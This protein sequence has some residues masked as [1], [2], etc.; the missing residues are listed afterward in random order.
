MVCPDVDSVSSLTLPEHWARDFFMAALCL[1]LQLNAESLERLEPLSALF[2]HSESVLLLAATAQ[3]NLRN[4]AEAQGLF[5]ELSERD[6][7][8]IEG[9]SGRRLQAYASTEGCV[10]ALAMALSHGD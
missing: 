8:R 10:S 3:Y 5:E 6:P 4:Y 2:P 1:E 7:H 9:K